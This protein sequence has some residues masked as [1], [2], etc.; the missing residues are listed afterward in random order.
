[1]NKCQSQTEEGGVSDFRPEMGQIDIKRYKSQ[2]REAGGLDLVTLT[3]N[4]TR[5]WSMEH[6]VKGLHTK[7]TPNIFWTANDHSPKVKD[8]I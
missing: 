7:Y 1:M 5:H 2:T 8:I 3:L 4:L 6:L